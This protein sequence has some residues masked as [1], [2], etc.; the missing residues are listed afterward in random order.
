[1]WKKRSLD[2][3]TYK[4]P[5]SEF[6]KIYVSDNQSFNGGFILFLFIGLNHTQTHWV[7]E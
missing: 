2:F 1:M 7:F 4:E 6:K 5:M 3:P